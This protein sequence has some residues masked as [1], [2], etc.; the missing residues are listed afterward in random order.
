M[1]VDGLSNHHGCGVG[2]ILQT[3][4]IEKMEYATRIGF[5]ATH[6]EV[7]Y[8]ALLAGLRVATELGVESLDIFSDS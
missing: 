3:P 4:S 2:L 5:K 6:N 8:E 7:E 1:F